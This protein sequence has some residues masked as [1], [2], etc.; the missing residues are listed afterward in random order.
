MII[1]EQHIIA[2]IIG[3]WRCGA[4]YYEIAEAVEQPYKTVEM[5]IETY[6]Y[7]LKHDNH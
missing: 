5:I 6:K 7:N 1:K 3:M 4:E 2:A